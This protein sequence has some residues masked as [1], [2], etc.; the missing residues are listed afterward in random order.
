L[1]GSHD[2]GDGQLLLVDLRLGRRVAERRPQGVDVLPAQAEPLQRP[3]QLALEVLQRVLFLPR[4]AAAVALD[5]V[6][7]QARRRGAGAELQAELPADQRADVLVVGHAQAVAQ[8]FADDGGA[9]VGPPEEVAGDDP[10]A[11]VGV[12]RLGGARRDG[13]GPAAEDRP[14]GVLDDRRHRDDVLQA[15]ERLQALPRQRDGRPLPGVLQPLLDQGTA[16]ALPLLVAHLPLDAHLVSRHAGLVALPLRV[17]VDLPQEQ[18]AVRLALDGVLHALA[19]RQAEDQ[20]ERAEDDAERGQ[21]GPRLLLPQGRE[22]QAEQVGEAHA[23][24][25]LDDGMTG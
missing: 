1:A 20:H 2:P 18:V 10:V 19:Q 14:A 3:R 17:D 6:D 12:V 25:P 8:E 11:V 21:R 5:E 4:E 22:R 16:D 7:V 23:R 13:L 15:A 9:L 24:A